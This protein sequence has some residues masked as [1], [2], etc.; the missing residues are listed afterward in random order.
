MIRL[1]AIQMVSTPDVMRN[2]QQ[3]G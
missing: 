3:A 2:L 1:A